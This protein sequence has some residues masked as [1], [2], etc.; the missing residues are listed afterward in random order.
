MRVKQSKQRLTSSFLTLTGISTSLYL[1]I[2]LDSVVYVPLFLL[3][4]LRGMAGL[5][6]SKKYIAL[7]LLSISVVAFLLS[8][9]NA[10]QFGLFN[11]LSFSLLIVAVA[12]AW[13]LYQYNAIR[14]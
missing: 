12:S 11:S 8:V 6:G 1:F 3:V 4:S 13:K 14:W 5:I 7:S 9:Y 2:F 10:I